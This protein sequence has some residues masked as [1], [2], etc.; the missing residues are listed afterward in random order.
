MIVSV[1]DNTVFHVSLITDMQHM[2]NMQRKLLKLL[3]EN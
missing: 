3:F 1:A 2:K